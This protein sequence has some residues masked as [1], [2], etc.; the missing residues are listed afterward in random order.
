M[1]G[2]NDYTVDQRGDVGS[3]VR[4][5]SLQAIESCLPTLVDDNQ[6]SRSTIDRSVACCIKQ[7]V[8]KLDNVREVAAR[9]MVTIIEQA[10]QSSEQSDSCIRHGDQ[11]VAALEDRA[12]WRNRS[13]VLAR[14][15][16]LVP[17]SVYRTALLEG[18]ISTVVSWKSPRKSIAKSST[19]FIFPSPPRAQIRH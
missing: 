1:L 3:W 8:E 5:A 18:A 7:T 9:T 10:G 13:H 11:I 19:L 17:Y 15:L 16:E 2:F 4:L 6:L 14:M 12:E